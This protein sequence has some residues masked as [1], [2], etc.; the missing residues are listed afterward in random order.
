MIATVS[1]ATTKSS[2]RRA[3][4]NVAIGI[5]SLLS[6][7]STARAQ[8]ARQARDSIV[9]LAS[10]AEDRLRVA[11]LRGDARQD[12]FLLRTA[13]R[14]TRNADTARGWHVDVVAPQYRAIRNSSLPYSLNQGPL[15]AGAGWNQDASAGATIVYGG[16]DARVRLVAAPSYVQSNNLEFQVIPSPQTDSTNRSPWANPFHPLPESIDL[17]LRFGERPRRRV[18][19]GQSSLTVDVRAVS[20]GAATE[21]LWWGP[22]IENAIVLSNNAPGFPHLFIQAR[23]PVRTRAGTFDAQW[24]LG[25]LRESEFFDSDPSNDTRSLSGLAA[26]WTTP[27]D[28]NLTLGLTRLVMGARGGNAFPIG[29]AFDV[30]RTV[31]HLNVDLGSP[32]PKDARDQITSLFARWLFPDAGFEAYVEWARFEEPRSLHDFLEFPGHSEGY[33][34]GFQWARPLDA[35]QTFRLQGEASYLEPDPSLRARPT[36]I[37]YTSRGVPQGFTNR[38]QTLG[39]AI[40]PGAS[41]QWLAGDYLA[42]RWRLGSYLGRIRWDNGVLPEPIVPG[43]KRQDVTL[44][45]GLR[46]GLSWRDVDLTVDFAHAARFNYLFQAFVAADGLHTK[47]VDLLNNTLS[48]TLSTPIRN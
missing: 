46:G 11:Q 28:T 32:V 48:F 29:A 10:D 9:R 34:L 43:F 13:S 25:Q 21:N 20:F 24:I 15:W 39:A 36:A 7:A 12:V 1:R 26:T 30:F 47:G 8:D 35:K 2:R 16:R 38:G 17:P 5:A 33:T 18:D 4:W 23:D 42:P 27:F 14:L 22:G 19:P 41:D 44:L 37:T 6:T 31:G 3:L 45:A 40:G